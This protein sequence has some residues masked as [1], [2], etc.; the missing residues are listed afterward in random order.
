MFKKSIKFNSIPVL[1][2]NR[3]GAART[4]TL[5]NI[6]IVASIFPFKMTKFHEANITKKIQLSLISK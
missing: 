5:S 3:K 4:A 2:P 1:Y 6:I